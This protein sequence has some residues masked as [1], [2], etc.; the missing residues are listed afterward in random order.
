MT[1]R[2]DDL[3]GFYR[4]GDDQSRTD[5]NGYDGDT[6]KYEMDNANFNCVVSPFF[7]ILHFEPRDTK[8]K[9]TIGKYARQDAEETE[10]NGRLCRER[11][12]L[13]LNRC[14]RCLFS[15][16]KQRVDGIAVVE[17]KQHDDRDVRH[18][19]LEQGMVCV[20]DLMLVFAVIGA[21]GWSNAAILVSG[22]RVLSAGMDASIKFITAILVL[23]RLLWLTG[24][25]YFL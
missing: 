16:C 15:C 1:S 20:G 24:I 19:G 23:K 2:N 3:P 11:K 6:E 13:C 4:A 25:E 10:E 22:G 21:E 18:D 17:V 14:S 5:G 7:S 12:G 9:D 8:L